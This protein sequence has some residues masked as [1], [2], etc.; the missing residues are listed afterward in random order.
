[1]FFGVS[2]EGG[3]SMLLL[4][5]L[6]AMHGWKETLSPKLSNFKHFHGPHTVFLRG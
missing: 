5:V 3:H 4:T 2:F 6:L 1:L